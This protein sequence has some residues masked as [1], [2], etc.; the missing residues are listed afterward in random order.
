M[1]R[2][3]MTVL[4]KMGTAVAAAVAAI[5]AAATMVSCVNFDDSEIWDK[6]N[7][8]EQRIE[9]LEKV[10]GRL[11]AN[12]DA[13]QSVMIALQENDYVTGVTKI[14][15]DGVEIGY[16]LSFA[17]G[18]TVTIYHGQDG[19]D[20]QDG[21]DGLNSPAPKIGIRKAADGEYYWTADEEW[22]TDENG[23]KIPAVYNKSKDGKYITPM[24]RVA[25]EGWYISFDDGN[26]WKF[27][28][29]LD[30][31]G[32][33]AIFTDIEIGDSYI[34]LT[35][36]DGTVLEIPTNIVYESSQSLVNRLN[37]NASSLQAIVKALRKGEHI[38]SVMPLVEKYAIAVF[39]FFSDGDPVEPEFIEFY[40][41]SCYYG[42]ASQMNILELM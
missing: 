26:S 35:T 36:N 28:R 7:E 42:S 18:G 11:N 9:E 33:G 30:S 32:N 17:K 20:G 3:I 37:T 21:E 22:L 5:A 24:F 14:C 38:S 39:N 34:I 8:H 29:N 23:E 19:Q 4:A 31:A 1:K 41:G 25:D 10:C 2:Y 16:S 13:L 27:Y 15:E 12:I 40:N 6:L